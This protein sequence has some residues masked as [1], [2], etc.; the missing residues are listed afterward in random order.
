MQRAACAPTPLRRER[1]QGSTDRCTYQRSPYDLFGSFCRFLHTGALVLRYSNL[2][3]WQ[4]KMTLRRWPEQ[5][6]TELIRWR[7]SMQRL[8][9]VVPIECRDNVAR[10]PLIGRTIARYPAFF[11]SFLS[12]GSGDL[13]LD[14]GLV[15]PE[16]LPYLG[17][18][19]SICNSADEL[20]QFMPR[21]APL[22]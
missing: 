19:G 22:Q 12:G 5:G 8:L 10:I 11:F 16:E 14:V 17:N 3:I 9:N 13:G 15:R 6:G 18:R 2:Y 21:L 1:A 20:G 7:W 4:R